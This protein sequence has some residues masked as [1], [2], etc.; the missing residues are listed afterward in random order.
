MKNPDRFALTTAAALAAASLTPQAGAQ[1]AQKPASNADRHTIQAEMIGSTATDPTMLGIQLAF[2]KKIESTCPD[3]ASC[4]G[5]IDDHFK[6][7]MAWGVDTAF[8]SGKDAQ[9]KPASSAGYSLKRGTE[10]IANEHLTLSLITAFSKNLYAVF[11][12]GG[13]FE[14]R[15]MSGLGGLSGDCFGLGFVTQW[16]FHFPVP[17][18]DDQIYA[19]TQ[20]FI[21]GPQLFHQDNFG[22]KYKMPDPP[23]FYYG[24]GIAKSF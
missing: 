6:L 2:R 20:F 3:S 7:S 10:F 11:S 16:E 21:P 17:G 5:N 19:T 8:M 13:G 12:Q 23:V 4:E 9:L 15:S 14:L 18:K 24:L 1:E 22:G